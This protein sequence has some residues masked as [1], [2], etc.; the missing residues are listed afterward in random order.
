MTGGRN[1]YNLGMGLKS[2]NRDIDSEILELVWILE[3]A[4]GPKFQ[5]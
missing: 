3:L 1:I 5:L 4:Q 2:A